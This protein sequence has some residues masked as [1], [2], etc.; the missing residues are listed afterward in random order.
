MGKIVTFPMDDDRR[1][2]LRMVQTLEWQTPAMGRRFWRSALDSLRLKLAADGLDDD[3]IDRRVRQIAATVE[4]EL[5]ERADAG[6][7]LPY[8]AA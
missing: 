5:Q 7:P 4:T 2:V 3:A 8:E 6:A 1:L